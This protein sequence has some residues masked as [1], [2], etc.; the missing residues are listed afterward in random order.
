[1]ESIHIGLDLERPGAASRSALGS[2]SELTE[3]VSSI[4]REYEIFSVMTQWR[5]RNIGY[6][7]VFNAW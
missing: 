2:N 1:V 4:A 3:S 7:V 5:R 6:S